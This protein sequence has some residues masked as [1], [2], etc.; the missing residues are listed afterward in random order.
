MKIEITLPTIQEQQ[1]YVFEAATGA[2]IKQLKANL[3]APRLPSQIEVD[4]GQYP[5]THLL[6][7]NEG[8]E[9]PA[10]DIVGAYFR[11]FQEAF[12][13][14]NT[15]AKMAA[16]LGVSSDRRVREYKQGRTKVPYGV[17]R[18]FLVLTG[19]VPQEIT[20]VLAFMG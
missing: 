1:A 12:P 5:R 19:R 17:W 10:P 9:A 13:Q 20:P 14:Y 18:Q 2:G 7:E 6:R 15:D 11:H 3:L 4:E 8:W 16:L